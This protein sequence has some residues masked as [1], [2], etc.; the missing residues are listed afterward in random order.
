MSNR[1]E[2]THFI[3]VW[4][5]KEDATPEYSCHSRPINI[6]GLDKNLASTI[7]YNLF[8]VALFL[9]RPKTPQEQANSIYY[10]LN[11]QK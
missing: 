9:I 10:P 6:R 8:T 7:Q 3:E 5:D 2:P 1:I 11:E 4:S